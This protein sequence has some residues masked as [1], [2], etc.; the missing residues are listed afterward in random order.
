[1]LYPFIV[2]G[3]LVVFVSMVGAENEHVA[4]RGIVGSV[5]EYALPEDGT[6]TELTC[7]ELKSIPI[8]CQARTVIV[9]VPSA[10]CV[11]V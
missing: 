3:M 1:V 9:L 11:T 6:Y 2:T 8:S 7:P 5:I 10:L 4:A